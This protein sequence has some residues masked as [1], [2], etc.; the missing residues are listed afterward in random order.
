MF[1]VLDSGFVV[2]DL[3]MCVRDALCE[4]GHDLIQVLVCGLILSPIHRS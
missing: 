4:Q 1:R 3:A 2:W